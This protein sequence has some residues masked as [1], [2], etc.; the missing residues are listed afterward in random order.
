MLWS[1]NPGR[2]Q[3]DHQVSQSV[4]H[5]HSLVAS[6]GRGGNA[7]EEDTQPY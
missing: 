1:H 7:E 5:V 3:Y 6:Y 4:G 2:L